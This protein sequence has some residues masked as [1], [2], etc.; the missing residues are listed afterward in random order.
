MSEMAFTFILAV[1]E[2]TEKSLKLTKKIT[3]IHKT[4]MFSMNTAK[5]LVFLPRFHYS[6]MKLHEISKIRSLISYEN[7]NTKYPNC[8]AKMYDGAESEEYIY[9]SNQVCNH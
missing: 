3:N 5:I 2:K 8:G 1:T 6:Q 9:Y 4:D 7:K